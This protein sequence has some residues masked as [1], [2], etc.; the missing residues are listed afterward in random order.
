LV[1]VLRKIDGEVLEVVDG[2]VL[3]RL[4]Q[5]I[6][7]LL[8]ALHLGPLASDHLDLVLYGI[9]DLPLLER[10]DVAYL[11]CRGVHLELQTDHHR[12][13]HI[14]VRLGLHL[15]RDPLQEIVHELHQLR[16]IGMDTLR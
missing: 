16:L 7:S 14:D 12:P 13:E 9:V 4:R 3:D 10:L 6:E 11:H 1:I 2:E 5:R 15:R 8:H